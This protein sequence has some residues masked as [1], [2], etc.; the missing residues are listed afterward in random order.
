MTLRRHLP[1]ALIAALLLAFAGASGVLAPVAHAQTEEDPEPEVADQGP[2]AEAV[3]DR[4]LAVELVGGVDTPFGVAGG[5]IEFAPWRYLAFY[6]GGG[7]GRDGGRF[8]GGVHGRYPIGNAAVGLMLGFGGG[9]ISWESTGG[10]MFLARRHWDMALFFH[11]GIT[12]EYR[13]PEGIFG[14]IGFGMD[15][16]ITPEEPDAC[17]LGPANGSGSGEPYGSAADTLALPIRG[18]AGLTIGYALD[19]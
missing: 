19:L 13:W 4:L 17:S 11:S 9:A 10:E 8:A 14:R 3:Y 18:W 16:L 7:I 6:A 1:Y 5:V 2:E 15:G 12:F